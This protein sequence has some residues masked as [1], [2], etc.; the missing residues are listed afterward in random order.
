V[1][2]RNGFRA[3]AI[4]PPPPCRENERVRVALADDSMITREG[5]VMLLER[6]NIEVVASAGTAKELEAAII[7]RPPDVA[8]LD[9][10]MP[11]TFTDE[12]IR[13]AGRIRSDHPA[14]GVLVLSHHLEPV[15]ATR[16]ISE[17]PERTGYLLKDR[18][19]D[20]AVLVDALSRIAAGETV[21][22]PTIVARL[23]GRNRAA[24]PLD[25]LTS[26]ERDVLALVA[27]GLSNRAIA[28]RLFIAE[29]TVE[30][31]VSSTFEKLGLDGAPG[32]H[33]RVLAVLA[34]LR[35]S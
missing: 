6:A 35:E 9:I 30:S 12:G 8:I 5:L 28:E 25:D 34:Y 11:P 33:R 26:R 2:A 13:A 23:L 18:V 10:R 7:Q 4:D 24:G 21:I 14:V 20:I 15:Y 22:D 16:L 29:R 27:E 3:V 31:H 17:Y 32:S 1:P 19:S